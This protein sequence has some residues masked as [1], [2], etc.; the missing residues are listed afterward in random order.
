MSET[1]HFTTLAIRE[2]TTFPISALKSSF[3][4]TIKIILMK[5]HV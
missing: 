2:Q 5:I 4:M 1:S 3:R